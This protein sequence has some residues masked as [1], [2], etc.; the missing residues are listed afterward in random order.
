MRRTLITLGTNELIGT[1]HKG[2]RPWFDKLFKS[3]WKDGTAPEKWDG[4]A[5]ERIV[6]ILQKLTS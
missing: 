1:D 2:F 5:G 4:K 3:E 6:N